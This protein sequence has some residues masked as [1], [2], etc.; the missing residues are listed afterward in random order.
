[1]ANFQRGSGTAHT[2]RVCWMIQRSCHV[3][4]P[5]HPHRTNARSTYLLPVTLSRSF[6]CASARAPRTSY[7]AFK[8]VVLVVVV[9]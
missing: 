3:C 6:L 7:P 8:L 4:L 2:G 1:M 5:Q 9:V